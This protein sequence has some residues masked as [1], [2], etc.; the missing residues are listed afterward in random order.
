M[1]KITQLESGQPVIFYLENE[2]V[3]MYSINSG[4][5][6]NHGIIFTDVESDFEICSELKLV[7]YIS[8]SNQAVISSMENL[9]IREDYIIEGNPQSQATFSIRLSRF[10]TYAKDFTLLKSDKIISHFNVFSY[11]SLIYLFVFYSSQDFDIY[12]IN[13]D[14]SIVNLSSKQ[15]NSSNPDSKSKMTKQHNEELEKL[16]A[17]FNQILDDKDSEIENLK[18]IQTN[19]TNQYNE[20]SDYTGKLQD[21]VRKLRCNY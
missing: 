10:S 20:L 11:D 9:N 19:I 6:R 18:E 17:Y 12:S 2:K 21:E 8:L 5:I 15:Y 1:Y 7:Y 14:Y 13:S 3:T 4:R 16:Q